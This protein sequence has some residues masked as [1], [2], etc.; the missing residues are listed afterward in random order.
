MRKSPVSAA[1]RKACLVSCCLATFISGCA[2][3][4]TSPLQ[5]VT[6]PN[7][8]STQVQTG[9]VILLVA[10]PTSGVIHPSLQK[11]LTFQGVDD[12]LRVTFGPVTRNFSAAIQFEGVPVGTTGIHVFDPQNPKL[13]GEVEVVV[14]P[15]G[16]TYASDVVLIPSRSATGRV[17]SPKEGDPIAAGSG[18]IQASLS[19]LGPAGSS[20]IMAG[21]DAA[22]VT[23]AMVDQHP[24]KTNSWLS[25]V[26]WSDNHTPY[27][28]G[29]R[30]E[31]NWQQPIYP[32]PWNIRYNM[33][34][35]L[36]ALRGLNLGLER[37]RSNAGANLPSPG[38]FGA[39]QSAQWTQI[40]ATFDVRSLSIDP[41]FKPLQMKVA[42][43]GDYDAD[44]VLRG[45]DDPDFDA[46]GLPINATL[47]MTVV[48]GNPILYF[49]AVGLPKVN[50]GA[51]F[52]G[53]PTNTPGSIDLGAGKT[54]GY[55][56]FTANFDQYGTGTIV[57]F[58][59][60]AGASLQTT[61]NLD[62]AKLTFQNT[63]TGNNYFAI[64]ALPSA[65]DATPANLQH[66]AAS[67]FCV[68]TNTRVT[69]TH[70][71]KGQTVDATYTMTTQDVLGSGNIK[72]VSG[73]LPNHYQNGPAGVPVLQAGPSPLGGMTFKSVR[74]NLKVYNAAQFTC[75][76]QYAG[77]LPWL[78]PLDDADGRAKLGQWIEV[79]KRR[80]G[81]TAPPY[82]GTYLERG[83]QAYELGKFL[84]RNGLAAASIADNNVTPASDPALAKQITDETKAAIE[85]YFRQNPS[86]PD[87]QVKKNE[88]APYYV[89]YDAR[90]GALNQYPNGTG[91]SDIFPSD[92]NVKPYESYGAVTR[93]NDHHFHY[94]YYIF[95]AA[96]IALRDPVWGSQYKD[97]INQMIFDVANDPAVNPNPILQ[98]PRMR[99]W[100]AY[101]NMCY[102]AGLSAP[103]GEGN[104]EESISEEINFWTGV[105]LWGAATGQDA[106]VEHGICHYAAASH[107]SWTYFFDPAGITTQL[108]KD[109]GGPAE[110]NWPGEGAVRLFDGFTRWDTFFGV[111]PAFA[112]AI[113]MIPVTGGSFYHA[114][115]SNYVKDV[116]KAYDDSVTKFTIDPL[117]PQGQNAFDGLNQWIEGPAHFYALFAKYCA[118]GDPTNALARYF[119]V[120]S[121]YNAVGTAPNNLIVPNDKFTDVGDSGVWTYH[122]CHY[123]ETH[124]KPDPSVTTSDTPFYMSFV[125]TANNKR[126]YAAYNHTNG[127]M[128]VNFSDGG[129]LNVPAHQ[130]ASKTVTAP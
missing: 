58:Y 14:K 53:V 49:K 114:L 1:L 36:P 40:Q 128:T 31:M 88:A 84:G 69:Y 108:T 125:D 94:G 120:P 9:K 74:G 70:N 25:P 22:S 26:L 13:F 86:Y 109:T 102:A 103:D 66:L 127:A 32:K 126:T 92:T 50:L 87:G 10:E 34:A 16:T 83:Q 7:S 93:N 85:L 110:T 38:G 20:P 24:Y 118:M 106:L 30:Q 113:V 111:H 47:Q 99:N 21:V 107:T 43:V 54:V 6:L 79:L 73:L 116:M 55:N 3:D 77:I 17:V 63:T 28:I 57:V 33:Q 65:A 100:D 91:P 39:N 2:S 44:F 71:A 129:S 12:D 29:G 82:T 51:F 130:L 80:N 115:N 76:Y 8:G 72:A 19:S 23:G 64:A 121:D 90:V 35:E 97:A 15:G 101:Q 81:T 95:A 61:T 119:N 98:F 45:V 18:F 5:T 11:N 46:T 78:P 122:W 59:D 112:R 104:N 41:G 89:Y 67:A 60:H 52:S 124:G 48:R 37:V 27:Y 4:G 117:K 62:P 68:P 105:I 123:M 56:V 96:Q 75:R 42:R